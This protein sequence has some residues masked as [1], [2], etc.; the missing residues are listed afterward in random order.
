MYNTT[1]YQQQ[2]QLFIH[3]S[4]DQIRQHYPVKEH[5]DMNG[6][7]HLNL[8]MQEVSHEEYQHHHSNNRHNRKKH[9]HWVTP[10]NHKNL[11][12]VYD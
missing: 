7:V 5:K 4:E 11:R 9:N 12:L 3:I 1:M 10:S 6:E 8:P 2:G